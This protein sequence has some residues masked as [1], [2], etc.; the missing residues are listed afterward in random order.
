MAALLISM[1]K[2]ENFLFLPII[3]L[4]FYSISK[5]NETSIDLNVFDTFYVIQSGI[6]TGLFACWL[7]VVILLL[8]LIRRRQGLVHRKFVFTYNTLTLLFFGVFML[9]VWHTSPANG[10]GYS[11]TE[12]DALIFKNKLR[13]VAVWCFLVVQ[14]IFLIYFFIQ[15]AK[16]PVPAKSQGN[17]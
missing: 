2:I 9:G 6:V 4:V 17:V 5:Y 10:A 3:V 15:F 7:F 16:K 12:L 11:N 8:K 13:L 14:V 1:K